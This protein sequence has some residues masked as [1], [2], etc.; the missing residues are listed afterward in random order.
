MLSDNLRHGIF[1]LVQDN[2]MFPPFVF[3]AFHSYNPFLISFLL[4][5]LDEVTH[6][7]YSM[8]KSF[9]NRPCVWALLLVALR[10]HYAPSVD[11]VADFPFFQ[12]FISTM[13]ETFWSQLSTSLK[14][15]SLVYPTIH[16]DCSTTLVRLL[17]DRISPPWLSQSW[18]CHL[19]PSFS[20]SIGHIPWFS[21]FPR[22]IR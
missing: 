3:S 9:R 8:I 7:T 13:I 19:M 20:F 22:S 1:K 16:A 10:R 15:R 12:I 14:R 11:S 6:P 5:P 17:W 21:S 2:L 4:S 18:L